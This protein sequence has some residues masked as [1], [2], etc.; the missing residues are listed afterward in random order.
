MF[1]RF[2]LLAL[3][4]VE[5]QRDKH[6]KPTKHGSA[7]DVVHRIVP[8]G[9]TLGEA[10]AWYLNRVVIPR[11]RW[12]VAAL[13]GGLIILTLVLG[14]FGYLLEKSLAARMFHDALFL[15]AGFLLAYAAFSTVEVSSRLSDRLW[16]T[17]KS[18]AG[19]WFDAKLLRIAS[20]GAAALIVAYWY[21]PAK[22]A[23]TATSVGADT[24]MGTAFLFAGSLIFVGSS[25]LTR[26]V[27]LIGLVVL[28]K[29]LG[30]YGMFLIL[31]PWAVYPTY[32]LYDQIYAGSALLFLMLIL[33][34]TV[35]P[36]W[37]YNY[38][39]KSSGNR[40]TVQSTTVA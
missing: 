1:A 8:L 3:N 40:V 31:T 17:S 37:L 4:V 2:Q 5:S 20:F 32:S 35:M 11:L 21:I 18:M 14:G 13:A 7:S 15:A 28:G 38:F 27:K 9:L 36:L 24:R 33:D 34:F 10:R 19:S 22:L 23:T 25:F 26:R 16:S 12:A 29:V 30:L 39:V 6:G